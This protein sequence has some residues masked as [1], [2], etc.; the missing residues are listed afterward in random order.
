MSIADRTLLID[1]QQFGLDRILAHV[2]L[3]TVAAILERE[4][5][6]EAAVKQMLTARNQRGGRVGLCIIVMRPTFVPD[7][8]D[9]SLR[10]TL[11]QDFIS[12]ENP[13]INFSIQGTR[14]PAETCA[15]E[16]FQ[17]FAFAPLGANSKQV[18]SAAPDGAVVPDDTFDGFNAWRTRLQAK[19]AC[20]SDTRCGPPLIDPD[21]GAGSQTVTLTTATS[22]AQ[23]YYT[24]DGSYP[25]Q[26]N[27]TLYTA[28]FVPGAGKT[29]IAA[30][31]KTG[32]QQSG[33]SQVIFS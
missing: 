3:A 30:A 29:L 26:G 17:L 5:V 8:D 18:Y 9:S 7:G 6:T 11:Y 15:L 31:Q 21:S 10:G 20:P 27:G 2:P 1:S 19:V 28:P 33:L 23:I 12:I 32:L 25:R 22:G 13:S 24:L 16:L 14:I 4:A